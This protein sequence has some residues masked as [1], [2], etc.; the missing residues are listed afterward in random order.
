VRLQP[1]VERR[2]DARAAALIFLVRE[3]DGVVLAIGFE[4]AVAHPVAV[5]VQ[6]AKRRMS[7]TQRSSGAS[8]FDHPLRQH[9]AGA[10]AEAMPKAL[11]PA[12]TN[13]L[14]HSGALARG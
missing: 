8:P 11:K 14:A 10:A 4:R 3:A 2:D 7:T 1:L 9:P 5:A 13:M 12:P 6:V